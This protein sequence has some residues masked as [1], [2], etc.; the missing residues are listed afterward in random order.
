MPVETNEALSR[1]L[2]NVAFNLE[3]T[4]QLGFEFVGWS[5]TPGGAIIDAKTNIEAIA[6][7]NVNYYAVFEANE[8]CLIPSLIDGTTVLNKECSPYYHEYGRMD[9]RSGCFDD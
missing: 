6:T 4:S 2:E 5:H 7:E 1:Y 9:K 3:A 8:V